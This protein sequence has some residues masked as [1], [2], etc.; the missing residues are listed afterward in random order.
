M[1]ESRGE[2]VNMDNMR[3]ML[4]DRGV[5]VADVARSLGITQQ[6]VYNKLKGKTEFKA[7]EVAEIARMLGCK[8]E[9]LL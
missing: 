3:R 2:E 7:S 4:R 8:V 6:S 9:E 1:Y 5:S